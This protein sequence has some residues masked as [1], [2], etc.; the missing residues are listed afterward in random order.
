MALRHEQT[1]RVRPQRGLNAYADP[2]VA[3]LL[4]GGAAERADARAQFGLLAK[5]ANA[6]LSTGTARGAKS[7]GATP[8]CSN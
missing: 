8:G 4:S 7:A 6:C 1:T 3:T 2:M 5:R